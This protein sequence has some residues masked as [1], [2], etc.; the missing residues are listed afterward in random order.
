MSRRIDEQVVEMRFDNKDFQ[1]RVQSTIQSLSKLKENLNFKGVQK[2]FQTITNAAK[3]VD[4][5]SMKDSLQTVQTQFSALQ[6]AGVTALANIT[7]SAVNAGKQMLK[8]LTIQPILSGF[9]E[10]ETQLGAV[11]TILANT[12]SKGTTMSDVTAALDEL[13]TYADKTIYNFSEMTKNIGTFTAAGVD[14][15]K[16]VAAIKGIANLGAMSGSTAAQVNTAMYQLSQALAAGRV[17]LMDWNS[18]VN[19]GMGG[20]QFQNALKRTAEHFGTNVD[21]MIKKYGSFRESLTQGGWLTADVLT[22][23]LKQIS[24]AYQESDLIAQGYTADQAHAIAQMAQTAEDAATKVKSFTQLMDT[25]QESVGSGWAKTFQLLFGD[26]EEARNFWTDINNIIGPMIQASSDARNNLLESAMDSSFQKFSKSL[27]E[28]KIPIE[29]FQVALKEISSGAGVDLNALINQYGSLEGALKSGAISAD[30]VS[31]ALQRIGLSA[32]D[33]NITAQDLM[34]TINDTSGRQFFLGSIENAIKAILGPLNAIKTGIREAFAIEPGSFRGMLEKIYNFTS[35]ITMSDESLDKL[36]R[37]VR[38]VASVIRFFTSILSGGFGIA[39]SIVTAILDNF[40]LHILDITALIGDLLYWFTNWIRTGQILTDAINLLSAAFEFL[41]TPLRAVFDWF[42]KLPVIR[43]IVKVFNDVKKSIEEFVNGVGEYFSNLTKIDPTQ[44]VQTMVSNIQSAFAQLG[45][46]IV[47]FFSNLDWN[48][49]L[50]GL[51]RFGDSVRT[52]FSNVAKEFETIGPDLIA[53]LQ[54]GLS[55]GIGKVISI[56]QDIA[57]KIIEAAK[58]VL[59]IHSPSTVF[60]DIGQNI[61]QGLING[62][63]SLM[64]GV[65]DIIGNLVDNIKEL[66]S[67]IDWGMI[68]GVGLGVGSFTAFYKLASA[69]ENITSPLDALGDIGESASKALDQFGKSM[70]TFRGKIRADSM[71]SIATAILMLAGAVAVLTLIDQSKLLG[72]V[73]AVVVLAGVITAMSVALDKLNTGSVL[74]S[75]K[76]IGTMVSI[77]IA[78]LAFAGALKIISSIDAAG[79]DSAMNAVSKFGILLTALAAISAIAPDNDMRAMGSMMRGVAVAFVAIA[80]AMKIIGG[81]D[82]ASLDQAMD[83][84]GKLA[85]VFIALEAFN[86]LSSGAKGLGTAFVGFAASIAILTFI[87]SQL[88]GLDQGAIDSGI[89]A[90][91]TLAIV[92]GVIIG[93]G[94]LVGGK[95]VSKI[96]SGLLEI[97]ASIAIMAGIATALSKVDKGALLQGISAIALLA[98]VVL[99]IVGIMKLMGSGQVAKVGASLL[100]ISVSI[101]ILAGISVLL[102]MVDPGNLAKGII[103]VGFLSAFV[104]G[105]TLA[106][107]K[108]KNV[109]GTMIGIAAAIGVMAAA[110][111]ILSFIDPSRLAPAVAAIGILGAIIAL[112]ENQA[113]HVKGAMGAIIAIDACIV[114]IGAVLVALSSIDPSSNLQNATALSMV[115][116][117]MVAALK[118]LDTVNGISKSALVGVV[119]MSAAVAVIGVILSQMAGLN[120][121]ASLANAEA[122]SLVLLAMSASLLILDQVQSISPTALIGLAG[123]GVV[124]AEIGA[125]LGVMDALNVE[126]SMGTAQAISYLLG[127][128]TGVFAVLAILGPL[129]TGVIPAVGSMIA[130]VSALGGFVTAVGALNTYVPEL[131]MFIS[132]AAPVFEGVGAALGSLVGGFVGGALESLSS[133]LGPVADNLSDFMTR[134]SPFLEGVKSVSPESASAVGNLAAAIGTLTASGLLNSITEFITGGSSMTQFA[135][136]LVPFGEAM[137]KYSNAVTGLDAGAVTASATAAQALSELSNNLPKEGGLAQ[138]IFGDSTD[139]GSFGAQL[140]M[141]GT[142]LKMYS[143]AVAGIDIASIQNS[144]TAGQALSDLASTLPKEGG[145]AQAIFGEADLGNFGSEL[146]AFGLAL[147]LYSSSVSGLDVASI[148]SSVQAGQALTDLKN[149]LPKEDGWWETV[150]GGGSGDMANFGQELASFGKALGAYGKSIADVD[151]SQ[152]TTATSQVNRIINM[153]SRFSD[154]EVGDADGITG[155]LSKMATSLKEFTPDIGTSLATA[156]IGIGLFTSAL[157][158]IS[159][160]NFASISSGLTQFG[161]SI[162]TLPALVSGAGAAVSAAMQQIVSSIMASGPL[163]AV[164]FTAA[165]TMGAMGIIAASPMIVAAGVAMATSFTTSTA[166]A[167]TSGSVAVIAAITAMFASIL[168]AI[169]TFGTAANTTA[170]TYGQM[171]MRSYASGIQSGGAQAVSTMRSIIS[172]VVASMNQGASQAYS[173][174]RNISAGLARGIAAGQSGAISA[175]RNLAVNAL[176]A[177]KAALDSHS[178]SREFEKLGMYSDQGL[179]QG[180]TKFGSI[181]EVASRDVAVSSLTTMADSFSKVDDLIQNGVDVKPTISPVLDLNNLNV[182][183]RRASSMLNLN[184]SVDVSR[185]NDSNINLAQ[186]ILDGQLKTQQSNQQVIDAVTGL[187]DDLNNFLTSETGDVNLYIDSKQVASTTGKA[188]NRRLQ[189]LSKRGGLK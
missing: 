102:G 170:Q 141:F 115:L 33:A 155:A 123:L 76:I 11:Q 7:N 36:R 22:E 47:N 4:F 116:L 185:I 86:S 138:A 58:A 104:A 21:G 40:N 8:S 1:Q 179:A 118:V 43:D 12:A 71:K 164:G 106:T 165:M 160:I 57:T 28:A 73:G 26:F 34:S 184:G 90:V 173:I 65:F 83:A 53:G 10:Y 49:V 94:T 3:N 84:I 153:F 62:I 39:F 148:Q 178:P 27:S 45:T 145:L 128:M 52:Y 51:S 172:Q 105:M 60:F 142:S 132:N 120:P 95:N 59:G 146:V 158:P 100:M 122:L 176:N 96:G 175:A 136:Q 157:A 124:V 147:K 37:T 81:M 82:S 32:E 85:I 89:D 50:D 180:F 6:V 72:A 139:L 119:A 130:A 117:A 186:E 156:S 108:A 44:A 133:S 137:K 87:I 152:I 16:S 74:D 101:G 166:S 150:F 5:N 183:T 77:G 154:F 129:S 162:S 23:T 91:T 69:L 67:S 18:V 161:T 98:G 75:A 68:F 15:D 80:A 13:N 149:A 121:Q 135:E 107:K 24:G 63:K 25:L 134:L 109:Q 159:M 187:R 169:I 14:L 140:V 88:S 131:Q 125:I 144:A 70:K 78:I 188:M 163:I 79:L 143:N 66:A 17:S 127:T 64:D 171:L 114:A 112:M 2:G 19:A 46:S 93:I 56:I 42:A 174:G 48:A 151:F 126:G 189:V 182:D 31:Q 41:T 111:A 54:N 113:Q 38:G 55:S 20:E 9:Q 97:S 29:Q 61:I 99:G 181:V 177:A 103:A 30:M 92:M 167:I 35:A 168:M 110:V